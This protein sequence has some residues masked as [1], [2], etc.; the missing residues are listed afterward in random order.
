M[1]RG[2][3][4]AVTLWLAAL[5]FCAYWLLRHLTITADLSAFL[6]AAATRSQ[7][8]LVKQ[9][10]EG[11]ASRLILIGRASCRERV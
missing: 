6:P 2:D 11:V 3:R 7:A 5:L 10:R 4:A 8:L 9:L 1:T